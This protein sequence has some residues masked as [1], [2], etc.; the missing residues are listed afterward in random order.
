MKC[1]PVLGSEN[2]QTL[3]GSFSSVSKPIFATRYSSFSTFQDLPGLHTFGPLPIQN[4]RKS[5]SNVF[6]IFVRISAKNHDFAT[7]FIEICTD[8]DDLFFISPN[9]L[10]NVEKSQQSQ[11]F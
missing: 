9:I 4:I 11:N 10:E 5:S 3:E 2:D 1:N 6:R 7:I 8:F